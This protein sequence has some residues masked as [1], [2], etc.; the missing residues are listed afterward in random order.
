VAFSQIGDLRSV[1]L[2]VNIL[3]LT[4]IAMPVS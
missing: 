2:Q 3:A 4:G 1:V